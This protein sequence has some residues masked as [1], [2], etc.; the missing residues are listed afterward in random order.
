MHVPTVWV[1]VCPQWMMLI[2]HSTV[3]GE[4]MVFPEDGVY[5]VRGPLYGGT[6][7]GM[8]CCGCEPMERG[9]CGHVVL[10]AHPSESQSKPLSLPHPPRC[11]RLPMLCPVHRSHPA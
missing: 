11:T 8:G 7:V 9:M 4:S 2:G 5:R 10:C 3:D 1:G 6:S